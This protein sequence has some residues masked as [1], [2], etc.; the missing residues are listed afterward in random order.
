MNSLKLVLGKKRL[1]FFTWRVIFVFMLVASLFLVFTSPVYSVSDPDSIDIYSCKVFENTFE[2]GDMLFVARYNIYY[3]SEPSEDAEYTFIF[4][5]MNTDNSTLFFSRPINYYQHNIISIYV[6]S[7]QVVSAGLVYGTE[8]RV[9]VTGSPAFFP[10][11][12]EGVNMVTRT[13]A[14][15]DWNTDGSLMSKELLAIHCIDLASELESDWG[16]TL[17][18]TTTTGSQ[19]LN[20]V[21]TIV[22]LDAIPNLNDILSSLFY[23]SS[24]TLDIDYHTVNAT[25]ETSTTISSK[26]G[27]S[28]SNAFAGIGDF[29]GISE[30]MSAGLWIL[31]FALSIASIIFLASGNSTGALLLSIPVVVLGVD[32]GAIP[33]SIFF[34]IVLLV[35][36]YVFYFIWLRG[37]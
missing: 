28:I 19:V 27:T 29:F 17:L 6:D 30:Q 18:T 32:L 35:V 11:L 15:S 9:R 4:E 12:A 21:G 2:T 31:L 36:A 37:T 20:A 34:T 25:L 26:L 24:T 8:Y 23:L 16:I 14:V 33:Y 22:F 1:L 7:D 13:L 3:A 10:S 5:I